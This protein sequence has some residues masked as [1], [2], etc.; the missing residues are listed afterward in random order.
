MSLSPAALPTPS[1]PAVPHPGRSL[2]QWQREDP[3]DSACRGRRGTSRGAGISQA[4]EATGPLGHCGEARRTEPS[5]CQTDRKCGPEGRPAHSTG[6]QAGRQ[7]E[8]PAGASLIL[9]QTAP[10]PSPGPGLPH[11]HLGSAGPPAR[12]ALPST[13]C[14]C[15]DP[16]KR[17]GGSPPQIPGNFGRQRDGHG[18]I[19]SLG[20]TSP[21]CSTWSGVQPTQPEAN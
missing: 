7:P 17:T 14:L 4:S 12:P 3:S 5:D 15:K 20:N 21:H 16:S 9:K 2:R 8:A 6:G 11:P 13:P 1:W 18:P 10:F 19:F